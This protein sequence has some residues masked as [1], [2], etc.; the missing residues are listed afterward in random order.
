MESDAPFHGESSLRYTL[1]IAGIP[2]E[3][4]EDDQLQYLEVLHNNLKC[5]VQEAQRGLE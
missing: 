3:R 5:A 1:T 2:V 4:L